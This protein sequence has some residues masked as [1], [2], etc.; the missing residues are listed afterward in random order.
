MAHS[1]SSRKGS[2]SSAG[3][4]GPSASTAA[5]IRPLRPRMRSAWPTSMTFGMAVA[6]ELRIARAMVGLVA[7]G[8]ERAGGDEGARGRAADAGIAVHHD[9]RA[10]VPALHEVDQVVDVLLG[11]VDVAVH[12]HGDVVHAEDQVVGLDD[13]GGPLHAVDQPQQRDDVA[14]AGFG[15]G[16]VQAGEGADVNHDAV[17]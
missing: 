4:P 1:R 15:D 3:L 17:T 11:R 7:L 16:V 8:I 9:R 14:R 10:A 13:A 5:I 6:D 2:P 12:R